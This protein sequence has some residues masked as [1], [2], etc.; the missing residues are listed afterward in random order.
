MCIHQVDKELQRKGIESLG[1]FLFHFVEYGRLVHS[2]LHD[3]G[4]DRVRDG[5]LPQCAPWRPSRLA[6][7]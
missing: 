3:E 4:V 1:G 6:A 2:R 7:R 5:L